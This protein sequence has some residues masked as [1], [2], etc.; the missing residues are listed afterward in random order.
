[1]AVRIKNIPGIIWAADLL[2]GKNP[3]PQG[4]NQ[5]QDSDSEFKALLDEKIAELQKEGA[6]ENGGSKI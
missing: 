3:L 4:K 1:M 5:K 2:V 6:N